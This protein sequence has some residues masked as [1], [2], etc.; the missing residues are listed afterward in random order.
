[1]GLLKTTATPND[2]NTYLLNGTKIFIT[3]GDHGMTENIIHLVLARL[4]GAPKGTKGI[5][6]FLVP[7]FFDTERNNVWPA[8]I[9]HKMG[10]KGSAT[11]VMNFDDAKGFLI[12]EAN[13]GLNIM[14]S[15]M[16]GARLNTGIQ[17]MAVASASYLGALEYAKDRL[18]MR[19]LTGAKF[20]N[21]AA[22]PIIVHPD[23]RKMLLTQK[24]ISEGC[25]AFT[26][27]TTKQIEISKHADN[28]EDRAR[29]DAMVAILTPIVKAFM[30]ETA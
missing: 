3:S 18:Q 28:P 20:P 22:D 13:K 2:D 4:P 29:A 25:R 1:L 27:F 9:E 10:L 15:M 21:K 23:V 30:T 7:K 14:F 12:G 17:G 16:N 11:C 24:S 8:S 19:S 5:S 26:Y 6:L